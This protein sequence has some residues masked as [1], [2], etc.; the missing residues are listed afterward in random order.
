[1]Y[2]IRAGATGPVGPVLAGPIFVRKRGVTGCVL[3]LH[4]ERER[5]A[6]ANIDVRMRICTR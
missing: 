3:T 6:C 1:M 2:T 5:P 4:S